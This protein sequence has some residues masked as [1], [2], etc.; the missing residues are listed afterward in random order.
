MLLTDFENWLSETK[1]ELEED[2]TV[3]FNL[4]NVSIS[5]NKVQANYKNLRIFNVKVNDKIWKSKV[6]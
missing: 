4:E 5:V 3:D 1:K 2:E 6:W